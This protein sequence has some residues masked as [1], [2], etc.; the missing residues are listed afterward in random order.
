MLESLLTLFSLSL[1]WLSP[2]LLL[3]F[4]SYVLLQGATSIAQAGQQGFIPDLVPYQKRGFASGLKGFM[5]IGGAL[6]GFVLLGMFLGEGQIGM[7]LLSI[8]LVLIITYLITVLLIH[9]PSL[10]APREQPILFDAFKIDFKE[11]SL[12]TRLVAARFL[13]LL[14]SLCC[15]PFF[16]VLCCGS[17]ASRT[18]CGC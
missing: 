1:L 10:P 15:W 11:Q 7:A 2:S 6:L 13:F 9:E 17:A 18:G 12:F 14:R 5:D 8:A 4:M 16:A 3:V